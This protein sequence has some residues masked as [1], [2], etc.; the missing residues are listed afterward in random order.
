MHEAVSAGVAFLCGAAVCERLHA[1]GE[2]QRATHS[3]LTSHLQANRSTVKV[4]DAHKAGVAA[5]VS[6]PDTLQP[7]GC[8][9]LHQQVGEECCA[10]GIGTALVPALSEA[11]N[12]L[13]GVCQLPDEVELCQAEARL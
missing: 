1:E 12:Q 9:A 2:K 7:Q 11:V 13:F 6:Y 10:V 4:P 5:F 3:T 8:V